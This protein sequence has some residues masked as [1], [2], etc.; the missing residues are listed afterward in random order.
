M[1]DAAIGFVLA[2]ARALHR[3]GT[4]AHRLEEAIVKVCRSLGLEAEAFT[5]PTAIVMSFGP[6]H[7]LRTRMMRVEG[8]EMDMGK[9]ERID[10]LGDDVIDHTITP[11]EATA[12]LQEIIASHPR[13]N[14]ALSTL[15]HGVTAGALAVFF[16]GT[17]PDVL[18]AGGIGLTLGLLAQ[19]IARSTDQTRVFGTIDVIVQSLTI[20]S[21]VFITGRLVQRLGM[22][23]LLVAVPV[24]TML[25]LT[26]SAPLPKP[27]RR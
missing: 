8:G 19:W 7:E 6:H 2:F 3:Y 9:L 23:A 24:V 1:N 13:F 14:R 26:E 20:L 16:G 27:R 11:E 17:L 4:P 5:T 18:L 21:Q 12:K 15:V 10:A 22:A 25:G